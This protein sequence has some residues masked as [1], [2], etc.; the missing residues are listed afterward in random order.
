MGQS[1][2]KGLKPGAPMSKGRR[3]QVTWLRQTT[4]LL[5]FPLFVLFRTSTDNLSLSLSAYI[6]KTP[7]IPIGSGSLGN[8]D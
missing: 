1:E 2:L 8:P 7:V 4:D 3:S 5:S 6:C